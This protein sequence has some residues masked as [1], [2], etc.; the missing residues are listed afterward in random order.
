M[1]KRNKFF[2]AVVAVCSMVSLSACDAI[3]GGPGDDNCHV[4]SEYRFHCDIDGGPTL[5]EG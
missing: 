5:H 1:K 2:A 4:D 3:F